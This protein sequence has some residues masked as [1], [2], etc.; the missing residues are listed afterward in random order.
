MQP[1]NLMKVSVIALATAFA[2]PAVAQD[3]TLLVDPEDLNYELP[4]DAT[5]YEKSAYGVLQKYCSDCHQEGVLGDGLTKPKAGFGHVL[6]MRRLANDPKFVAVGDPEKSKLYQVITGGAPAMP[7]NCWDPS[8]VPTE[9][10]L[11]QLQD[12]IIALGDTAPEPRTY[13]SL[14]DMYA[15]AHADLQA[16]PTNRRDRIRYISMRPMW[17]DPDVS[18]ENYQGYL[19]ATV[20]LM[21]ALSWNANVYKFEK[22]DEH[23]ILLRVFLPELDWTHETWGYL[24]AQYPY[25]MESDTDPYLGSLQHLSGSMTP[26]IRADW[27]TATASVSPLY[28]DMLG[29]PDTIQGLEAK[30]GMSMSSNILNEQVVRAGF[31]DSGVSSHNRLIERHPL[32]TGFFWTS[33]DFAGSKGRQSFFEYPLGPIDAYG[34]DLAFEHDGGESI[35]TLPNGFHA[36]Y[37]NTADGARLDVGP[38]S[39][40]RDTDYPDGTGEVVNGISCISCHSKGMRFNDDS[41]REVALNNLSLPASARQTIDAI[42]PGKDVINE[43]FQRD[44]DAFLNTLASAGIEPSI[45]AA[46]LEP[47]RGLFVYHVDYFVDFNQAANELGLTAEQL[48]SRMAFAGHDMAGLL[49]RL[50]IS[51]IARDEWTAAYPVLLDKLTDYRPYKTDHV[52]TADLSYS[53]KQIVKDTDYAPVKKVKVVKPVEYKP[54]DPGYVPPAADYKPG[55]PGYVPPAADHKPGDPG[56]VPPAA[57]Y[58]PGDPGYVP[59]AND[60]VVKDDNY[61]P[62]GTDYVVK[63][64]EP[65]KTHND[66][67]KYGGDYDPVQHSVAAQSHLTVYTNQTTYK[68]GDELQVF[69]EPRH[70]CRLTLIS[71][72]DDHDSC[73]LYPFPGLDDIVIPG[74]TQYVFPPKGALR[75][76]EPGLETILAIC[77]GGQAAIDKVTRDTSKVSCS[78][79]HKAVSKDHYEGIVN[80]TLVLDLNAGAKDAKKSDSGVDYRAVS[81]HNPDVTKAQISVVVREY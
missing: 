31:Q 67:K 57:D 10:E 29:L 59:P 63:G 42:Y 45:K 56:Y 54:G 80:E 6:D 65:I 12:W 53:V 61:K 62:T 71:I 75:T 44:S 51:P 23:G 8:C 69:I 35:F 32:G 17:N 16:Q 55:D 70:D 46:G 9:A 81:K 18:D 19:A 22:V 72:D 43:Y 26:V 76:S 74:G 1:N 41:V 5:D 27:F 28:Y 36:Y 68:V 79:G 7:D 34:P 58:K 48:R 2:L 66:A 60:Y 47:V 37:L 24:E 11:Q 73:V 13:I 50:D 15:M 4:A 64:D 3:Q 39:I 21:N 78:V 14:A 49:T 30:L 52:V 25:A 33:Y 20:K 40:V 38:T 77:N